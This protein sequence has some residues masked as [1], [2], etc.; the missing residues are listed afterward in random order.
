MNNRLSLVLIAGIVF[1]LSIG[2][3]MVGKKNAWQPVRQKKAPVV[4]HVQYPE[5]TLSI[6]A[7][8]Y[9]GNVINLESLENANP[10]I[11]PDHLFPGNDIFV[12]EHLVKTREPMPEEFVS[13]SYHRSKNNKA[14]EK[15][16]KVPVRKEPAPLPETEGEDEFEIFGPK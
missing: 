12:P 1:S 14:A 10:N 9:T 13:K 6:I 11:N 4:H 3:S 2:C 5:E 16:V 7:E 15:S 8:W